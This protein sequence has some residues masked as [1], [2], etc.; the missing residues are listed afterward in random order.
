MERRGQSREVRGEE[1]WGEERIRCTIKL[2]ENISLWNSAV[3][4]FRKMKKVL[5]IPLKIGLCAFA[6]HQSVVCALELA[7]RCRRPVEF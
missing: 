3:T 4:I 6:M 7:C 5:L 1:G 2:A